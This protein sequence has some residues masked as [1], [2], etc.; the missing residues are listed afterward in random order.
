MV[1]IPKGMDAAAFLKTFNIPENSE[2]SISSVV[3]PY[4]FYNITKN[5]NNNVLIY[6]F[7][8]LAGNIIYTITLPDGFYSTTDLNNYFQNFCISNGLY[9]V[10]AAGQNVYYAS[11]QYNPTYYANQIIVF[12]VPTSLPVGYTQ[13]ANWA[14]YPTAI[15]TPLFNIPSGMGIYLGFTPNFYPFTATSAQQSFNSNITPLGSNV[16]SILMRCS[17]VNNRVGAMTDMLDAFPINST[18]GSN[19]TYSPPFQKWVKASSGSFT[20]MNIQFVDQNFNPI[21]INDNNVLIT[22]LI[23]K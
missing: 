15:I 22:I 19:I 9:L 21:M 5:Y 2:I 1:N 4:S 11:I 20:S 12:P 8:H 16:N 18:F 13:P 14:G 3:L 6:Y 10:N 23:K 7:P 17:I